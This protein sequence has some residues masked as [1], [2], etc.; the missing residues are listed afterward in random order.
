[1]DH[2]RRRALAHAAHDCPPW[3]AVSQQTQRWLA[4]GGF[5]Q[6]VQ[7][8]RVLLRL[9]AGRAATPSA[10]ALE[11]RTRPSSPESGHRARYDGHKRKKGSKLP[12]AVDTL[13]PRL[14]LQG[15]PAHEQEREQVEELAESV[16]EVTGERVAWAFV[17][18]GAG[19]KRGPNRRPSGIPLEAAKLSAAKRGF[20]LPPRRGGVER[21]LAW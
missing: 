8:L 12:R 15:T 11:S 14:V 1:M 13:G 16:Q 9:A 4:A 21:S 17:D 3:A 10:V 19:A 18:Q 7:D 6:L 2:A 5:E 20:G